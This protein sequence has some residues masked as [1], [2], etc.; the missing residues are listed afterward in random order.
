MGRVVKKPINQHQYLENANLALRAMARDGIKLV[1]IG[2]EDD[3]KYISL[4]K[5]NI[6]YSRMIYQAHKE[7]WVFF[8][9][10]LSTGMGML[11]LMD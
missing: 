1:N 11:Y 3:V 10:L 2:K 8:T 4:D 7:K 5:V 9:K 6:K